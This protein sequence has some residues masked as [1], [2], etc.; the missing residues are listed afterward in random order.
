MFYHRSINALR[1]HVDSSLLL[2]ERLSNSLFLIFWR[3]IR[4]LFLVFYIHDVSYLY[5]Q[6]WLREI[7]DISVFKLTEILLIFLDVLSFVHL[8]ITWYGVLPEISQTYF[9]PT[10]IGYPKSSIQLQNQIS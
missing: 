7:D 6:V 1:S 10:T 3:T 4:E 5:S 9:F 2:I 8:A